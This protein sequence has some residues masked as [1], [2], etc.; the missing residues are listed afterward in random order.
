M[1]TALSDGSRRLGSLALVALAL[2]LALPSA[3]RAADD[4]FCYGGVKPI[5]PDTERDTGASY[6]FSCRAAITGFVLMSTS[7]LA[8]FDV[9]ADVFNSPG[10]GGALRGDD[11]FGECEGELP[12]YGFRCTGTY[13]GLG[14]FVRASFDGVE[15][16]CARDSAGHVQARYSLVVV[17]QTGK[18]AGPYELGKPKGCPKARKAKAG[19]RKHKS[20]SKRT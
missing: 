6:E 13:T 19:H 8:S 12:S 17:N 9:T 11:R 7:Q 15:S 20:R 2:A 3:A 5:K 14:R 4:Q 10:E 16:P 1:H 18:V